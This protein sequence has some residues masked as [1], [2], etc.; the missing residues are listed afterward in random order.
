MNIKKYLQEQAEKDAEAFLNEADELFIKQLVENDSS[1]TVAQSRRKKSKSFWAVLGSVAT[2]VIAAIIIFPSVFVNRGANDIHYKDGN[3][4]EVACQFEEMQPNLKYFQVEENVSSPYRITLN[5]DS[6]SNDK[7]YYT[8]E[9]ATIIAK[10]KLNLVINDKYIYNF[11]LSDN[12]ITVDLS[13][14]TISYAKSGISGMGVEVRYLGYI[15]LQTEIIYIDY[16]QMIDIGEQAF[17]DDIESII[18]V[19][20]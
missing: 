5:Y 11:E 16:Q 19:K 13:S 10:Y 15:K 2:V 8:L 3:I 9:G 20:N 14:Y 7:L 17:F 6:V 12:L 4:I 1:A 18:K